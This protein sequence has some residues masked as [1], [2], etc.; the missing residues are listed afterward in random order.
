MPTGNKPGPQDLAFSVV[1]PQVTSRK[2]TNRWPLGEVTLRVSDSR[3]G[4]T[5]I[6]ELS[7]V[8]AYRG[9]YNKAELIDQ[10]FLQK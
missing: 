2:S 1:R 9:G 6:E 7:T 3:V 5:S 4:N 8:H 10:A